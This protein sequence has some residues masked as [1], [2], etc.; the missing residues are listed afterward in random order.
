[1]KFIILY[2]FVGI[3]YA[4]T[5]YFILGY[6]DTGLTMNINMNYILDKTKTL[7]RKKTQL[8]KAR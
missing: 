2:I 4:L 1:M 8:R 3:L 6:M 7:K 5:I